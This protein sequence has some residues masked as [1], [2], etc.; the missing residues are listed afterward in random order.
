MISSE[1]NGKF[2]MTQR[3]WDIHQGRINEKFE[4]LVKHRK[5]DQESL[6]KYRQE[7]QESIKTQFTE[8]KEL[9]DTKIKSNEK[10]S[11]NNS[12]VNKSLI[13]A[14]ISGVA[15]VLGIFFERIMFLQEHKTEMLV[16]LTALETKVEQLELDITHLVALIP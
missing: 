11:D 1:E 10:W 12:R 14:V 7:D 5:E 15:A 16:K 3:E 6:V 13:V 2:Y 8:L 4:D 9:I